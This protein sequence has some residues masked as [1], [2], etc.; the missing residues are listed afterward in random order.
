MSQTGWAGAAAP[1]LA[2]ARAA[3][4]LLRTMGAASVQFLF[5][6]AG[7]ATGDGA[8][9]GL[10]QPQMEEVT[11]A[12]VLVHA[13]QCLGEFKEQFELV[14]AASTLSQLSEQRGGGDVSG[15]LL[16][17]AA[18]RWGGRSYRVTKTIAELFA[19]SEYLYRLQVME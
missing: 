19:G 6:V 5:P 11:V 3:E 9:I 14:I 1:A 13:L 10:A 7:S 18:V 2:T 4:T 8:Q 16:R 15:L 12:P 17:V